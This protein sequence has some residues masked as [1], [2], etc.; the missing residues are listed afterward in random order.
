LIQYFFDVRQ[1][2]RHNS[3]VLPTPVPLYVLM[4]FCPAFSIVI[5]SKYLLTMGSKSI[6][7]S[8]LPILIL[9]T[10]FLCVFYINLW[11]EILKIDPEYMD[12]I[13]IYSRVESQS[14][15]LPNISMN[16]YPNAS[17]FFAG[18]AKFSH[19]PLR[20]TYLSDKIRNSIGIYVDDVKSK[21]L[22]LND[23]ILISVFSY[24]AS[25]GMTDIDHNWVCYLKNYGIKA[26][27]FVV[28]ND[29]TSNN[30]TEYYSRIEREYQSVYEYITV[31]PFPT[32]LFWT[33]LSKKTLPS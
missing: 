19:D 26:T 2:V 18:M 29:R 23:T 27:F 30:D 8:I 13:E 9:L 5:A 25:T 4:S 32:E 24:K 28:S 3:R 21:L 17:A 10:I 20:K 16:D 33:L 6:S 15:I 31:V 14:R 22:K 1:S 11:S 7:F 12:P